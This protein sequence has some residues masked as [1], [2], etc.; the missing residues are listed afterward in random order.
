MLKSL[1]IVTN[2]SHLLFV[3]FH[4]NFSS[5]NMLKVFSSFLFSVSLFWCRLIY[6][7]KLL[8]DFDRISIEN[9]VMQSPIWELN[10]NVIVICFLSSQEIV[11]SLLWFVYSLARRKTLCREIPKKVLYVSNWAEV[12]SFQVREEDCVPSIH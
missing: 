3:H 9:S 2:S 7:K 6:L 11:F 5:S 8:L 4:R 1:E 10:G 12:F